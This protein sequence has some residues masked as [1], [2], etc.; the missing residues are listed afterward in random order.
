MKVSEYLK[1]EKEFLTD[2]RNGCL[3]KNPWGSTKTYDSRE[4]AIN[5]ILKTAA[6][7]IRF[8]ELENDIGMEIS[9]GR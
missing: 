6:I 4:T 8:K 9:S 2:I 3:Y 1:L 7:R 5:D